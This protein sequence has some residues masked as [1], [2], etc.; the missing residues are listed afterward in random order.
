[1]TRLTTILRFGACGCALALSVAAQ[2]APLPLDAAIILAAT[3]QKEWP[4][5]AFPALLDRGDEILVSFKRARS[6]AQ[7]P[8]AALE[9]VRLD[10]ATGR[11]GARRTL[12][13]LDGHIMQMGEWVRFP[14]G[15][16]ANYIDAQVP[17]SPTTRAGLRVVRSTDGGRTFGPVERVGPIDGVEYGYAFDAVSE[18]RTTWMLVMTFAN[19]PGG[20]PAPNARPPAGSV[21]VIRTEDHGRTWRFVRNLSREFGDVPIN[22]S[23]FIRHGAGWLVTTRGYDSRERLHLTDADFRLVRQTDLTALHPFITSHVG[24][25]RL[26]ARD[27]QAYLLGRNVAEK[28]KPMQ[29]ALFRLDVST[30]TAATHVV[31]DN[32]EHAP[33]SDGYYA[34]PWFRG[35]AAGTVMHVVTYKGVDRRPPDLVHLAFRWDDVK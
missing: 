33:V 11:A 6:H 22:E 1:M 8:G 32:A 35:Q 17:G 27:G 19:L 28:G 14:N 9:L 31:L 16:I 20:K 15:D 2:R 4:Y 7:D 26:F 25:P 34:V 30:L 12:A 10:P 24:R 5:L 23:A 13:Q 29:L 21:D 3:E 18:G